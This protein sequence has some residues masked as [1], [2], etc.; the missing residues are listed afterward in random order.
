[1]IEIVLLAAVK[2]RCHVKGFGL[3][4]FEPEETLSHLC[5]S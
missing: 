5:S 2:S 3:G 4:N 1:M